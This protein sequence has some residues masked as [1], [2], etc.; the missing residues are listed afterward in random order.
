MLTPRR[1]VLRKFEQSAFVLRS[2]AGH[3]PHPGQAG[4]G[5][6]HAMPMQQGPHPCMG[7]PS[8]MG[9]PMPQGPQGHQGYAHGPCQPCGPGYQMPHPPMNM[10]PQV[11]FQASAGRAPAPGPCSACSAKAV[12]LSRLSLLLRRPMHFGPGSAPVHRQ[13]P[14]SCKAL[15]GD[16]PPP[17]AE[18]SSDRSP[19]FQPVA[20]RKWA[21]AILLAREG[22]QHLNL[23]FMKLGSLRPPDMRGRP[24]GREPAGVLRRHVSVCMSTPPRKV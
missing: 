9:H 18:C 12:L 7:P 3:H 8:Q 13:L 4:P 24:R 1:A 11:S 21:W 19:F 15:A 16:A 5:Q 6:A 20:V 23:S 10:G 14:F 17:Q 2:K 22:L